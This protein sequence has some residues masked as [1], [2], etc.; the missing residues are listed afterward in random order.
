MD[1]AVAAEVFTPAAHAAL[2]AFPIAP[3]RVELVRVSENATFRVTDARDGA[4]HVLRLHRPGYHTTEE[5]HSER[6]WTRA[7]A[8]AGIAVPIPLLA[9]DGRDYVRVPVEAL[10]EVRE[11]GVTRWVEGELL[12]DRLEGVDDAGQLERWFGEQG[13]L[14]ARMHNQSSAWR[15]PPGFTRHAVDRDGLLGDAPHWGPFWDHPA[16]SPAERALVL[17]T[18]DRLRGV[19]DRYGQSPATYGLIHA[20]L[21]PGNVLVTEG[22]LTVIDF[23][24]AAFGWH[25]YDIAVALFFQRASP[26][27]PAIQRAF[28]AGYRGQRPLGEAHIAMIPLFI[29]VRGMAQ[30][31]WLHQRPEIE[32]S[33]YMTGA[34]DWICAECAAFEPPC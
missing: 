22:G 14:V 17:A 15:P 3:G 6:V 32:A 21:H 24:D 34:K 27:F 5:L 33:H 18:R 28:V 31:G 13:A 10:G 23:D 11:V 9:R 25:V 8:E 16:L 30:I 19:L 20:D 7:L 1:K 29:L 12:E 4:D 26:H 2:A